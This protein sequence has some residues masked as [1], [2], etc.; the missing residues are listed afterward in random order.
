MTDNINNYTD[1]GKLAGDKLE[2][3]LLNSKPMDRTMNLDAIRQRTYQK[4]HLREVRR[5]RVMRLSFIAAIAAGLV[6]LFV[7][8]PVS[9]VMCSVSR[10]QQ[11]VAEAQQPQTLRVPVGEKLTVVLSDGTHVTVNSNTTLTYPRQFVGDTREVSVKGEAYFEVAHDARHPFIVHT[12]SLRGRLLGTKVNVCSY[13]RSATD[14]VLAQGAV[15]VTMARHGMVR[16][17]PN[18]KV[19]VTNGELTGFGEVNAAEYTSWMDD[20]LYLHGETLSQVV[21]RL[22]NY[23]GTSFRIAAGGHQRLY[24]KLVLQPDLSGVL[25]CINAIVGTRSVEHSNQIIITK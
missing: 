5:A 4:R 9:R 19:T 25:D 13:D 2:A 21:K 3:F 15:E 23:Y 8:S 6:L 10:S 24:G 20:V 1:G 7:F 17:R 14:V 22:D 11:I 16:M 18:Q 12:N